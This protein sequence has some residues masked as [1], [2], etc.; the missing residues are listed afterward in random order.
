M[1]LLALVILL[2]PAPAVAA[3]PAERHFRIEARSF[4][5]APAVLSVN[6]G[7]RVTI[8]VVAQ[9]VMHGLY[10][11]G[12]GLSVTAEPGRTARLTFTADRPGAFRLRCSVTCGP[13][14]PF[15]LGKLTVGIN[16]LWWRAVA[17]A[18][19]IAFAVVFDHR[20]RQDPSSLSLPGPGSPR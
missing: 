11:D 13:L 9:D 10:V 7:D 2:T 12:Y 5:Y 8:D 18:A 1:A 14:H 17:L 19:L 6:P 16:W 3:P 4:E 20:L 15:M